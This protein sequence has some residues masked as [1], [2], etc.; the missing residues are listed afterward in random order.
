VPASPTLFLIAR[1]VVGALALFV[2]I[3]SSI[4]FEQRNPKHRIAACVPNYFSTDMTFGYSPADLVA[5][6]KNYHR[7]DFVAHREFIKNDMI[8][9]V[10]YSISLAALIFCLMPALAD[11]RRVHFLWLLPLVA[12]LFDYAENLSMRA[13]LDQYQS[14]AGAAGAGMMRLASVMTSIKLTL[15]YATFFVVLIGLIFS[16]VAAL[17][18]LRSA[19][20]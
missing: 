11:Y 3:Y 2:V 9:P 8:Y 7:K 18:F 12:A 15:L 4:Y 1:V 10:F 6:L 17:K 14:S 5:V 20:G 19:V 16:V 13:A